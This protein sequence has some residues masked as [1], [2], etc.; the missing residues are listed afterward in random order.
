[1]HDLILANQIMAEI[2]KVAKEKGIGNIKTVKLEMGSVALSHNNLPE[3]MDEIDPG[4]IQFLLE[5]LA[6]NSGLGKAIFD[7]K[8]IPGSTW[9]I[10]EI[11][12]L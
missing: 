5:K 12:G 1:M 4:N 10:R 6:E 2:K 7:I 11:E 9:K 3:H 8:K